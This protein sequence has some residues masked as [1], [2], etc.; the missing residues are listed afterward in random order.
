MKSKFL[1]IVLTYLACIG[2]V[3]AQTSNVRT[4]M[5]VGQVLSF[6]IMVGAAESQCVS[7]YEIIQNGWPQAR[8]ILISDLVAS[9]K[10]PEEATVMVEKTY[11]SG[12]SAPEQSGILKSCDY[13]L[14]ELQKFNKQF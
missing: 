14:S 5:N 1:F 11:V 6:S 10:T 2:V 9:R 4:P 12:R 3:Q 7:L 13:A 8:D